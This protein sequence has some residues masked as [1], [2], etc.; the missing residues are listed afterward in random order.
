VVHAHITAWFIGLILFFVAVSMY[1]SGNQKGAKIVHMILRVFYILIILSGGM[2]ISMSTMYLLKGLV[3]IWIIG[4]M[5]MTLGKTSKQEKATAGWIQF[6]V[7]LLLVLYLGLSLPYGF[8]P[9]M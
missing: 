4:A 1:K 6:I 7:A 5:E 9:F 8:H 3:G 2:L